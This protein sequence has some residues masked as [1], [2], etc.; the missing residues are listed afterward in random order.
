MIY[1]T[2]DVCCREIRV[3]VNDG[4][5]TELEFVEGC[6]GNLKGLAA[7]AVGREIGEVI[8]NLGGIKCKHRDTS[9]PD[10]LAIALKDLH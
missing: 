5:I 3:E 1:K 6:N 2:K 8:N 4:I 10:Q 9:C 7:L